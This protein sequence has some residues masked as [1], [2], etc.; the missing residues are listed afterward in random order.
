VAVNALLSTDFDVQ[1]INAMPRM[2]AVPV[3]VTAAALANSEVR[4]QE[5]P[6]L[7]VDDARTVQ[8]ADCLGDRED[9][10]CS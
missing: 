7:L 9:A 10:P 3:A 1:K 5:R 4:D 2:T 6:G 8:V